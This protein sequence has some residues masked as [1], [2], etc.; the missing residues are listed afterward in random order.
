MSAAQLY[1]VVPL[2][3]WL[4]NRVQYPALRCGLYV[5]IDGPGEFRLGTGVSLGEGTRIDLP[6]GSVLSLGGRVSISRHV[7]IAPDAGGRIGIGALTT[8]QDGCRIYGDV[9]VGQ[10]CIFAPNVFVSSGT[11]TFDALPHI[12]IQEQE[13]LAPAPPRPIRILGDCWFGI[14]VVIAPGVTVGRGCVVGANSVVTADLAP[15]QVAGGNPAR[16]IRKRLEFAPKPRIDAANEQDAPYFYDGF[17]LGRPHD[18]EWI[19]ASDFTL[20]LDRP[21]ARGVRLSASGI[22]ELRFA[23]EMR[24][25]AATP[26]IMEFDL[27]PGTSDL[28]FLNFRADRGCRVRWAELI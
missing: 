3:G 11:H 25:M 23:G 26:S 5:E 10:R 22:G 8:I 28:P 21:N 15:Y 1:R 16:V 7:H 4:A 24:P 9:S 27:K 17:D 18:G 14:N 6:A 12:P 19:A 2:L 20:A 13:R